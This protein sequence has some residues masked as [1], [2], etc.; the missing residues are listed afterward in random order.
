MFAITTTPHTEH[1]AH[2][3]SPERNAEA[4]TYNC[5]ALLYAEGQTWWVCFGF[6]PIDNFRPAHGKTSRT[7]QTERAAIAAARRWITSRR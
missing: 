1:G 6:G 7:Y 2:F 3:Y 5:A 4:H